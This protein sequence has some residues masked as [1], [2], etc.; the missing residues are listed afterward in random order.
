MTSTNSSGKSSVI[1]A[2][3]MAK[4]VKDNPSSLPYIPGYGNF[5]DL[6]SKL[7]HDDK[8]LISI[9]GDIGC[10]E[11]CLNKNNISIINESIQDIAFDYIGADR[12]GPRVTLPTMP[13]NKPVTIG[14]RGEHAVDFFNNFADVVIP[15]ELRHPNAQG[16][17]LRHQLNAWMSEITP[18]VDLHFNIFKNTDISSLNINEF[19][20]TNTGFGISYT[21]PIVLSALVM[22]SVGSEDNLS[23]KLK[24]WYINK[25]KIL[26]IENPEAHLHPSG[27]TKLG[28]LLTLVSNCGVQVIVETHSDHFVD[29][30]RLTVKQ[31]KTENPI[32]R[33][34]IFYFFSKEPVVQPTETKYEEIL[35]LP[36]GQLSK[37]PKGFFDQLRI[38]LSNLIR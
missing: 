36:D 12:Y 18:G 38:N 4:L 31:A 21:L 13:E 3:R 19:R 33:N 24:E 26:I 32:D 22:A 11:F 6:K 2:I 34:I 28:E 30:V 37:W 27:Q 7:T 14:S 20:S 9:S 17:I 25:N 5:N 23:A 35:V 29:G 16:N 1:Q 15:E 8:I 10:L